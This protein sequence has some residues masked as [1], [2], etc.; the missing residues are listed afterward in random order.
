MKSYSKEGKIAI[1]PAFHPIKTES[2]KKHNMP[3]CVGTLILPR[4]KKILL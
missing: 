1:S 2:E 3:A 4:G